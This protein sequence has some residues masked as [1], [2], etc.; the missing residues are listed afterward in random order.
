M[1]RKYG[2]DRIWRLA[3]GGEWTVAVILLA[4]LLAAVLRSLYPASLILTVLLFCAVF[5]GVIV[6]YFFRDPNR[7]VNAQPGVTVSPADG[8][9]VEVVEEFE[10]VYLNE[11]ARR[12]SIFLSVLNVHVQRVPISGTVKKIHHRPGRFMQAFRPEASAVNEYI[13]MVIESAYGRILVKQIAGILARRCVNYAGLEEEVKT[14][15]RFGLIRFGSRVDLFLPVKARV[16]VKAG[17][18]VYGGLT[19]IAQFDSGGDHAG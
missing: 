10:P 6:L 2:E 18:R 3:Q 1:K 12:V 11:Q 5:L 19:S 9:V 8:T 4:I 16:L 15:Q 17:D 13:A 7:Q 14:G